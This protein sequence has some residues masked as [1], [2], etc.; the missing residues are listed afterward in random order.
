MSRRSRTLF[1]ATMIAALGFG[2]TQALAS[3]GAPADDARACNPG[4]CSRDCKARGADGGR[5]VGGSCVCFI[6]AG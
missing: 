4:Q 1:T 5:C 2:A 3:P 6:Q